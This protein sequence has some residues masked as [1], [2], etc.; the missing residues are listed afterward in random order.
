M[1]E[2]RDKEGMDSTKCSGHYNTAVFTEAG[3]EWWKETAYCSEG[4]WRI[5]TDFPG[6]VGGVGGTTE[7]FEKESE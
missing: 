5:T 1:K 7:E 4:R 6:K 3:Q 2:C